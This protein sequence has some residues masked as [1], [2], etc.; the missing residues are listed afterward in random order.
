MNM[1]VF[2]VVRFEDHMT[3]RMKMRVFWDIAPCSLFGAA[4]RFRSAYCLHH[5]GDPPDYGSYTH[6]WNVGQ[7]ERDYTALYPRRLSSIFVVINAAIY[8]ST[9]F[10][11]IFPVLHECPVIIRECYYS[12]LQRSIRET[13]KDCRVID[14]GAVGD[15]FIVLMYL[16][17]WNIWYDRLL[18]CVRVWWKG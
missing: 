15:V 3:A 10:I 2:V 9:N 14:S 12:Y 6:L 18:Q 4:R 7:I 1:P 8:W 13:T 16:L 17:I 11:F 5:Q